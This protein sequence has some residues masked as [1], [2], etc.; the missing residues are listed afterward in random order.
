M[1]SLLKATRNT[2]LIL[3]LL[4]V[5]QCTNEQ[6]DSMDHASLIDAFF[7]STP[8]WANPKIEPEE[9]QFIENVEVKDSNTDD[10]YDCP[11]FER[12][13]VTTI[14]NFVSAGTNFGTIWPGALLQGKSLETGSLKPLSVGQK[15]APITLTTNLVLDK[16][17]ITIDPSSAN[18][19]QAVADFMIAAGKMPEGAG[20]GTMNFRIEEAT[21]F[22]QSMRQMGVSAGFTEPQS[23]V[24]LDGS[25]NVSKSRTSKTHTVVARFVQEMFT[26]RIADDMIYT[27]A[28]FFT[29]D[30]TATDL[31][32]LEKKGEIG[33]ENIPIYIESVT[34]GRILLFSLE[35]Q[36]VES[37]NKLETALAASMDKYAKAGGELDDKHDEIFST[38]SY[39]IFSAGGTGD[40]ANAMIG[41]LDWSKFF[42][43]S[44]A[45]TAVPISFVAKTVK[46]KQPVDLVFNLKYE[47]R[48][49][50]SI[51]E[52]IEPP[53][54]EVDY[55]EITV[56]WTNTDNTGLCFGGSSYGTCSPSA[57]VKLDKEISFTRL[58]LPNSYRR[59]FQLFPDDSME[60][61]V[62]SL[63]YLKV[64]G[65]LPNLTTKTALQKYNA[66]N[67]KEGNSTLRHT[68]SN[69]AGSVTLTYSISKVTHYK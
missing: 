28:D 32:E 30:Y 47:I 20:T 13:M 16:T 9:D 26:V 68:L 25:L 34:Y 43:D 2:L 60:F 8:S 12:N 56:E 27:P 10:S 67:L 65:L 50:C 24:G 22:E 48:D 14:R 19:Q 7:D 3:P 33:A 6:G 59:N 11:V 49:N 63:G 53:A 62:R 17:S 39:K 38:A 41:N 40:A 35:S 23:N 55:Y 42:V 4:V 52:V 18:A 31:E 64:S 15:R 29:S 1:K 61:W 36:S 58:T 54:P 66:Q 51:I 5:F 37:A 57:Y 69:L 21:T 44:P 45:S 46:D